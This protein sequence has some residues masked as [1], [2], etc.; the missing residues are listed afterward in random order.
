MSITRIAT[1]A[2]RNT[3]RIAIVSSSSQGSSKSRRC[4]PMSRSVNAIKQRSCHRF[5][6]RIT[7]FIQLIQKRFSDR[8]IET[9]NAAPRHLDQ[10]IESLRGSP[11]RGSIN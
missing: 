10:L 2:I 6:C 8:F 7:L 3:P 11:G 4:D 5:H 9:R 1:S